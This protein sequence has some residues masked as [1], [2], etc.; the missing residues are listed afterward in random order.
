[1]LLML[2]IP[3]AKAAIAHARRDATTNGTLPNIDQTLRIAQQIEGC[4]TPHYQHP[5]LGN[6][7][8]NKDRKKYFDLEL[9]FTII[10][11]RS[12]TLIGYRTHVDRYIASVSTSTSEQE[13]EI[14]NMYPE[15][16]SLPRDSPRT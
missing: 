6:Q 5:L 9:L 11:Q 15:G 13:N 2:A 16:I 10:A 8:E 14:F 12:D 1:M 7:D 4:F 3:E